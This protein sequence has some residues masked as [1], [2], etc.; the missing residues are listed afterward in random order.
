MS[1]VSRGRPKQTPKPGAPRKLAKRRL[2]QLVEEA[3]I[4]AYG[5]SEQRVGLL[6]PADRGRMTN[7]ARDLQ[8]RHQAQKPAH[9]S[10][11]FNA[12]D[13]G[14]RQRRIELAKRVPLVLQRPLDY[15]ARLAIQ[16]RN[17]LLGYVQIAAYNPHLGLL[18]PERCE[19]GHR[20]VYAGRREADVVT[21]S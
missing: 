16:H 6:S 20:T 1:H 11:C 17:R 8:L 14:P 2:N 15:L 5:E 9:R 3:I 13:H 18:R 19:G 12:H 7:V 10:G 4:D 21:T